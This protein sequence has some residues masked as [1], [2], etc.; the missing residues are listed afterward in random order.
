MTTKKEKLIIL[1]YEDGRV[2]VYYLAK[3]KTES[4]IQ[5]FMIQ[6]GHRLNNCSW[7]LSTEKIIIE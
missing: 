4:D 2:Y 7:M 5:L 6:K 1:D 3:R